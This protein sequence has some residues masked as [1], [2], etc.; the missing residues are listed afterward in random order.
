LICKQLNGFS[1][2]EML[3]ML[4]S[5]R[6]ILYDRCVELYEEEKEAHQKAQSRSSR[7]PRKR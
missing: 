2:N 1:W 3:D 6:A 4:D 5:E 7:P